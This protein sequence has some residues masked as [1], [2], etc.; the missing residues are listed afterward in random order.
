MPVANLFASS[1]TVQLI[2]TG[3]TLYPGTGVYLGPYAI[4]TLKNIKA[5][6][7]FVGVAGITAEGLYNSNALV[8]ETERLVMDAAEQVFVV[9]DRTKFGRHALSFLCDFSP[10]TQIITV[11]T[12]KDIEITTENITQND[13]ELIY[14]S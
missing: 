13:V 7:A 4:N 5:Q 1:T 6:K 2:S 10:I 11:D 12:D 9:A 14:A 3:G 8:V